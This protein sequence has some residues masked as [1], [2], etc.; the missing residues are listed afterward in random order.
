MQ[1]SNYV[2]DLENGEWEEN[3]TSDSEPGEDATRTHEV[4]Y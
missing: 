2:M 3:G 1:G 4:D